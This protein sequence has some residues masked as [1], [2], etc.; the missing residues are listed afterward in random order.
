MSD[1]VQPVQTQGS[2]LAAWIL[3]LLGWQIRYGGLPARQGV[4]LVYPHTSNWDFPIGLLGKWAMGFNVKFWAKDS[5]FK[6]PIFGAWMRWLGGIAVDRSAASG[7]VGA[8]V[9]RVREARQ[10]DELLWL[11][12]TPEGTRSWQPYWK[13]GFYLVA[14]QAQLPVALVALDFGRKCIAVDHFYQLSGDRDADLA[15][16]AAYYDGVRGKRPE[17]AGPVRFKP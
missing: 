10:T 9:K 6:L 16:I 8:I 11:V 14:E 15:H 12:V 2:A 7:M 13:S 3:R 4:F 5:L 1:T 17:L